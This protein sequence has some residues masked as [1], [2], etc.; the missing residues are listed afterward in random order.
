MT[1]LLHLVDFD[2]C[3]SN[4]GYIL[5]IL[6]AEKALCNDNGSRSCFGAG[7]SQLLF[8]AGLLFFAEHTTV[9]TKIRTIMI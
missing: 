9:L 3:F 1:Q 8:N 2:L 7:P 4:K 5:R 6:H